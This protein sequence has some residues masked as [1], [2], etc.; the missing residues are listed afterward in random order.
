MGLARV[1]PAGQSVF[2]DRDELKASQWLE[3]W[4]GQ[5]SFDIG[6]LGVPLS[7][8]SISHS[9]AFMFP[10]SVRQALGSFG[11]YHLDADIDLS[12]RLCAVDLGDV[13][14]H[15]TDMAWCHRNIEEAA[16]QLWSLPGDFVSCVIGGDHSISAP[17]IGALADS[18]QRPVGVIHFDAHH[19]MRNLED[20][21]RTNG[22]P[23]RTLLSSGQLDGTRLVQIGLRNFANAQAYTAYARD[24]G[25]TLYTMRKVRELGLSNV[26]DEAIRVAG[27]D[28]AILYVSFD[29][30]VLDQAHA[31]GVPA[32]GPFG[33]DIWEACDAMERLGQ[34]PNVHGFDWVCADPTVDVRNLTSRVAAS[35]FLHAAAG[36]AKRR[37]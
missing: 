37:P 12:E 6:V 25:V 32:P 34:L 7:K 14:M 21:G 24:H 19:D 26:L 31:P 18:S 17:L 22:T 13:E 20:G 4:D 2:R 30:D 29:L 23:F 16:R 1:K 10:Q 15:V 9:G 8:T 3:P 27:R 33:M 36:V 35:L 11:T 5:S 28:D